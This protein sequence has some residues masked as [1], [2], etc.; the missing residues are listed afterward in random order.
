MQFPA[1]RI[2]ELMTFDKNWDSAGLGIRETY[3]VGPDGLMRSDSRLFVNDP[4]K[5]K[6]EV[7]AAGT[8]PDIADN[9]FG[10]AAPRWCSR[11]RRTPPP[12]PRWASP[13]LCSPRTTSNR[14][15]QSHAP[16]SEHNSSLQ[17]AIVAKIDTTG[18]SNVAAFTRT[19][20][21]TTV[22]ISFSSFSPFIWRSCSSPDRRPRP[23]FAAHQCG[24]LPG[25]HSGRDAR[26]EIGDLTAAFNEMSGA[27][28]SRK[29]CSTSSAGS[30][31]SCSNR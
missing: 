8:P 15:L 2:N 22:G 3:L 14:T 7:I 10:R 26:D 6:Q 30:T 12:T 23:V 20:V 9:P 29:I 18:R 28:P 4:Q 11:W 31:T 25:G 24:R 5:F 27:S 13:G 19:L 16:V 21:L 17:W 1:S